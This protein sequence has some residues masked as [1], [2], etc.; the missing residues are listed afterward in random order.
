MDT[1]IDLLNCINSYMNMPDFTSILSDDR[2]LMN[3]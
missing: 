3:K 1:R 2:L